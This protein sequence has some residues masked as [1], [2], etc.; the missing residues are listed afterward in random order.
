MSPRRRVDVTGADEV[1][2]RAVVD[3]PRD[4]TPR[5]DYADWLDDRD[6]PRG[7]YLRTEHKWARR[8]VRSGPQIGA[9][10]NLIPARL[11][12]L[13]ATLDAVWVA[14]ISRPPVGVCCDHLQFHPV[15]GYSAKELNELEKVLETPLPPQYTAFR[16]NYSGE[17]SPPDGF[18]PDDDW[19]YPYPAFIHPQS[20]FY[21]G[22]SLF[23]AG[24]H[25]LIH[26]GNPN[27]RWDGDYVGGDALLIGISDGVA[28]R[29]YRCDLKEQTVGRLGDAAVM[30]LLENAVEHGTLA[31]LKNGRV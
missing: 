26:F 1:F 19:S 5:L 22:D 31:A 13:A 12:K 16:L 8:R 23:L 20:Q 30:D 2:I 27:C 15:G 25:R 9:T 29:V 11:R 17:L 6:D 18:D 4:E 7:P 3:G 24:P 21:S 10:S 14:R 28:D